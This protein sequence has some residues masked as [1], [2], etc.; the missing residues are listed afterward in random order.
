MECSLH[1]SG[2][3]SS[4]YPRAHPAEPALQPLRRLSKLVAVA[5]PHRRLLAGPAT[6]DRTL[7]NRASR[8]DLPQC[9][10]LDLLQRLVDRLGPHLAGTPCL[11]HRLP[12]GVDRLLQDPPDVLLQV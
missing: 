11:E 1:L 7:L 9:P 10:R 12:L 5:R 8:P 2:G 4:G 3:S 6:S